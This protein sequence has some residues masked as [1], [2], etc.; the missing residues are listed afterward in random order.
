[1]HLSVNFRVDFIDQC[2]ENKKNYYTISNTSTF[3]NL[4]ELSLLPSIVSF[5]LMGI[6]GNQG[7]HAVSSNCGKI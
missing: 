2:M 4:D 5:Q 3:F 1:M 7:K 6:M